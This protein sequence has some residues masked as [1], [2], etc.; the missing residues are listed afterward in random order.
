MIE[1]YFNNRRVCPPVLTLSLGF[2]F[3]L[4]QTVFLSWFICHCG[5][6]YPHPFYQLPIWSSLLVIPHLW[7]S[8][9]PAS[10]PPL[11]ENNSPPPLSSN[12]SHMFHTSTGQCNKP[13]ILALMIPFWGSFICPTL[14]Q[15]YSK[16]ILSSEYRLEP[17]SSTSPVV[18]PH[19]KS[20]QRFLVSSSKDL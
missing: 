19:R 16:C 20:N 3:H 12:L 9:S 10:S 14:F 17:A 4:P 11:Q 13:I 8:F 2:L 18:Y 6:L 7:Q 5:H 1:I 15:T